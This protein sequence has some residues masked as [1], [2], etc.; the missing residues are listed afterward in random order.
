MGRLQLPILFTGN[1]NHFR[2]ENVVQLSQLVSRYL[3]NKPN[4]IDSNRL[5]NC[6]RNCYM[7][8]VRDFNDNPVHY[9][10]DM[11][12]LL[13]TCYATQGW[14]SEKQITNIFEWMQ[15]QGWD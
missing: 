9:R 15:E 4:Q 11:R 7:D 3:E 10:V 2:R 12:M 14:F 8:L 6:I 13:S 1:Y 5:Y